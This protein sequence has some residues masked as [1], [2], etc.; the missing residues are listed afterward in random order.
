LSDSNDD[1]ND[2]RMNDNHDYHIDDGDATRNK[3]YDD[4]N[5]NRDSNL[6]RLVNSNR[7]SWYD[8]DDDDDDVRSPRVDTGD[9]RSQSFDDEKHSTTIL[10]DYDDGSGDSGK[11]FIDTPS[12][13]IDADSDDGDDERPILSSNTFEKQIKSNDDFDNDSNNHNDFDNRIT[14]NVA[15]EH[16]G[17]IGGRT[18]ATTDNRYDGDDGTDSIR[19]TELIDRY[20]SNSS[21]SHSEKQK[22]MINRSDNDYNDDDSDD[23][24]DNGGNGIG[25]RVSHRRSIHSRD[26]SR[27]QDD[28]NDDNDNDDDNGYDIMNKSNTSIN[29]K[30]NS[31]NVDSDGCDNN[32][33]RN[34]NMM[35]TMKLKKKKISNRTEHVS[36]MFAKYLHETHHDPRHISPSLQR[37]QSYLDNNNHFNHDNINHHDHHDDNSRHRSYSS[38]RGGVEHEKPP[39][40]P[41]SNTSK[42]ILKIS[43]TNAVDH[44]R[45]LSNH[46]QYHHHHH[47]TRDDDIRGGGVNGMSIIGKKL[48]KTVSRS[49]IDRLIQ[50]NRQ[51]SIQSLKGDGIDDCGNSIN[52]SKT[53]TTTTT[54]TTNTTSRMSTKTVDT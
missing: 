25:S 23:N 46:H 19:M 2:H 6:S 14:K 45:S 29:E 28:D 44:D 9:T 27:Y 50:A 21:Q 5:D 24:D 15:R 22:K 53:T 47:H 3:D 42:H 49:D 8:D 1:N 51:V 31:I 41:S 30:S 18:R 54:N 36:D 17:S 20:I 13:C 43:T 52:S 35:M 40:K 12:D 32:R 38:G 16:E 48:S 39:W 10:D 7:S 37:L 26:S 33:Y 4:D 11:P 34:H